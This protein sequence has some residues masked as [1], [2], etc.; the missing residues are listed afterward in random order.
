[1]NW[2]AAFTAATV[3]SGAVW[4]LLGLDGARPSLV[5]SA[6]AVFSV[7]FVVWAGLVS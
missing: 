1:M 3:V 7:M 5:W 4:V 6:F 2:V